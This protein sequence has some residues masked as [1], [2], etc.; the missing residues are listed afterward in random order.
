MKE[1]HL[2]VFSLWVDHE[3]PELGPQPLY[4]KGAEV[5]KASGLKPPPGLPWRLEDM[6]DTWFDIWDSDKNERLGTVKSDLAKWFES[7]G[8]G[9]RGDA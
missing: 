6:E 4:A 5:F 3:K 7:I 2:S 1:T 8:I 9:K